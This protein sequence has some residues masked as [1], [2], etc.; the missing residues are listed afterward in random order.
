VRRLKLP[1]FS[2]FLIQVLILFD[3][4]NILMILFSISWSLL[5]ICKMI[6]VCQYRNLDFVTKGKMNGALIRIKLWDFFHKKVSLMLIWESHIDKSSSLS[7]SFARKFNKNW[8]CNM[9][10]GILSL[11]LSYILSQTLS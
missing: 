7:W 4:F 11:M 10:N 2:L 9:P 3:S 6:F 5:K 8:L 1:I